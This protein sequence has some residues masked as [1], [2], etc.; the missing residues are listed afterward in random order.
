MISIAEARNATS[1]LY[2][3]GPPTGF[4]G[5]FGEDN[6]LACHFADKLNIPPGNVAISAPPRYSAGETYEV[7]LTLTR[8]GMIV[9]GFQL[10]AR[11]EDGGAQA[12]MLSLVEGD[13]AR[14][15][16]TTDRGVQYAYHKRPGTELTGRDS[17]RWALRWTAP[18]SGGGVVF[19]VAANAAND[20]D[21]Q[22]GDFVFTATARSA[23]AGAR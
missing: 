9:G 21:S 20:D 12:G 11:F 13:S 6:C 22:F 8:P 4:S 17:V 10:T 16:L 3:D 18:A 15:K 23:S 5:G 1:L 14:I 7:T 2:R 19:H